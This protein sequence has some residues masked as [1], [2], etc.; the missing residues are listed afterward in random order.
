MHRCTM[1]RVLPLE[2]EAGV[3]L[4]AVVILI[5]AIATAIA[6]AV[7]VEVASCD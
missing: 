7:A 6:I 3:A 4:G 1:Q 2:F 5:V